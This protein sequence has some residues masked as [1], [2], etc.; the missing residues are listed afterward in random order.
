MPLNLVALLVVIIIILGSILILYKQ[1]RVKDL[2]SFLFVIYLVFLAYVVTSYQTN[3][4]DSNLIPFKEICRYDIHSK[5]FIKN[6]VGN[7]LLFIPLGTFIT[8]KL[9][10]K[11]FYIIII[12]S[13]Y[14][15]VCIEIIQLL[16]GRVFDIDDILLN[17]FGGLIGYNIYIILRNNYHFI[18][19]M[20]KK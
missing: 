13:L 11:H 15:S 1:T 2:I 14:F 17:V 16:I 20:L 10:I 9:D 6:I 12:T 3:Y 18:C 19:K 7:I 4:L 8:Y 5:L